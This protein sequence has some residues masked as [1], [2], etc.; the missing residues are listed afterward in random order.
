MRINNRLINKSTKRQPGDLERELDALKRQNTLF[1]QLKRAA[2]LIVKAFS[3]L[4]KMIADGIQSAFNAIVD[5]LSENKNENFDQN[6]IQQ[7]PEFPK[8]QRFT[9]DL[10]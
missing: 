7:L 4:G 8:L 10:L 9:K 1:K 2:T 3:D 5:I 6:V